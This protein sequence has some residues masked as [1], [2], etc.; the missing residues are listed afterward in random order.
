MEEG[1]SH[2]ENSYSVHEYSITPSCWNR[3]E[4]YILMRER[5]EEGGREREGRRLL[6]RRE[7]TFIARVGH[8][9]IMLEETGISYIDEREGIGKEGG[10]IA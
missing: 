6:P 8:H 3:H 1:G 10:R 7:P 2:V 5:G 9:S 4:Y